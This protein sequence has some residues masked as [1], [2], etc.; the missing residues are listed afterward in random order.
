MGKGKRKINIQ[1]SLGAKGAATIQEQ[2]DR[3]IDHLAGTMSTVDIGFQP[4]DQ[5]VYEINLDRIQP[6]FTQPRHILPYDLRVSVQEGDIL[7]AEAMRELV[8]KAENGDTFAL[9]VL[10]GRGH[11]AIEENEDTVGETG[12]LLALARSIRGIGL[13][14][15]LNVYRIDDPTQPDQTSYRLGEGERR[16][17][18]H[19]LLVQQGYETFLRVKCIV[20]SMPDN[21][22]LI[23]QRQEAENAARVDLPAMARARSIKRIMDRLNIEMGT[24]VPRENTI[25]LPSQRELQVAVGQRVKSFTGRAISDRMVRNYLALLNLPPQAEDLAEAGQLTEKQLRPVKKLKTDEEQ[26]AWVR[27]IVEKKWSSRKVLEAVNEAQ[28]LP[29]KA[30]R[31]VSPQN[32]EHRFEKR[33][34]DAAK[35]VY[36]LA[37]MPQENYDN[38]VINLAIRANHDD[39]TR[40]ALHK[41]RQTLDDVLL[42]S[43]G[44]GEAEITEVNLLSIIPPLQG[45]KRHL[46]QDESA[47]LEVEAITG[48]QILEQLL[49][50]QRE[51]AIIASRLA[52]F[53]NQIESEAETLRAGDPLPLPTLQ[54]E[55]RPDYPDLMVYRVTSG[56]SIYW[57][58][59]L[60]TRRGESQFKTM[61]ADVVGVSFIEDD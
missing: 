27:Q 39:K 47:L 4:T 40:Q 55:K 5:R 3:S 32:I 13:R 59:E 19:H 44:F 43:E 25:K 21:E 35:T 8:L 58:H 34:I 49:V 38:A 51:D 2:M 24:R 31:E 33:V 18:A 52:P 14:Q 48:A 42:K 50:W 1:R 11:E 15:P 37:S 56:A 60:L 46:P 45:L 26:I 53:F 23:H 7:P 9:L 29:P 30:L 61:R 16:F 41:L 54:G 6:D 57:A 36:E 10:G 17:W 28:S 20:E 22:E 12:G